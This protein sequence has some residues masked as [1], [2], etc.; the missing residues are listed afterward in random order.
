M[1]IQDQRRELF[2]QWVAEKLGWGDDDLR[3]DRNGDY[4]W[5]EAR[6]R[7]DTWNAALD[8]VVIEIPSPISHFNAHSMRTAAIDA[9]EEHGLKV[10]P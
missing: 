8:S 5:L 6:E 9:I 4:F 10:A 1:N 7:L 2:E 3:R